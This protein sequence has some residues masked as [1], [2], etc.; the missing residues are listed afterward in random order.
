MVIDFDN[1]EQ[2]ENILL[3]IDLIRDAN[4][5]AS[6]NTVSALITELTLILADDTLEIDLLHD[7]ANYLDKICTILSRINA[8][9]Q[10]AGCDIS[11]KIAKLIN[12]ESDVPRFLD[13]LKENNVPAEYC[14]D[15][16]S[17]WC[18]GEDYAVLAEHCMK[19]QSAYNIDMTGVWK[20]LCANDSY[21]N[22]NWPKEVDKYKEIINGKIN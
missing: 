14:I 18:S 1:K 12:T 22:I 6:Q 15:L 7:E 16:F 10:I 8:D 11:S 17:D 9:I 2:I 21:P 5:D 19:I 13:M 20:W 3:F 4:N